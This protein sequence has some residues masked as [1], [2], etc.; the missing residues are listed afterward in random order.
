[1]FFS[2]YDR[3]A[4]TSAESCEG[5]A[6][7]LPVAMEK[8]HW[9]LSAMYRAPLAY[10]TCP[11][12]LITARTR[13]DLSARGPSS[14]P[15]LLVSY[16]SH[17]FLTSRSSWPAW[18]LLALSNQVPSRISVFAAFIKIHPTD[19]WSMPPSLSLDLLCLF[20]YISHLPY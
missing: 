10:Y 16:F 8:R 15:S 7:L 3:C 2:P 20:I 9:I 5:C 12:R 14:H 11:D 17:S 13:S 4:D 19:T 6:A 1:M 18:A